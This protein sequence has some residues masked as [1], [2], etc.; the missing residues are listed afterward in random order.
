MLWVVI[1][2]LSLGWWIDRY[3]R[4]RERTVPRGPNLDAIYE[5]FGN[6]D[7]I[8]GSGFLFLHYDLKNGQ[9]VTL[10]VSNAINHV[11]VTR[12]K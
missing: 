9:T 11:A 2:G 7:R 8:S 3:S 5:R 12:S 4:V 1:V 10:T 6:P